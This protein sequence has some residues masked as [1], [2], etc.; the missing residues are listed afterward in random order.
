MLE[1][2]KPLPGAQ[3]QLALVQR[4]AQRGLRQRRADMRG[5]VV[6]PFGGVAEVRAAVRQLG[7]EILQILL[8]I[9]I[10]IFL[11]QQRGRGV[12]DETGQQARLSILL[13]PHEM[14]RAASVNS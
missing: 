11:D 14:L 8:H 6:R 3:R 4:N 7:E 1:H 5:H 12:A 13:A 9:G 10:G 2:I